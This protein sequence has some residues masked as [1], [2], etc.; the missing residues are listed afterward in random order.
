MG[1]FR[2]AQAGALCSSTELVLEAL[3]TVA[4]T[5][6]RAG[7]VCMSHKVHL[8]SDT[9]ET[10]TTAVLGGGTRY[11]RKSQFAIYLLK[12]RILGSGI[13]RRVV[14][15]ERRRL[16]SGRWK[17]TRCALIKESTPGGVYMPCGTL[18]PPTPRTKWV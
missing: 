9:S 17:G 8:Q 10:P 3:A 11:V 6:E 2:V 7:S 12:R 14:V 15:Y 1:G 16:G 13:D 5:L 18:Q 4:Q